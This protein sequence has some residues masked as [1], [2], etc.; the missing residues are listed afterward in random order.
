VPNRRI[1]RAWARAAL[2]LVLPAALLAVVAD[3]AVAP[4]VAAADTSF[5]FQGGG[6]GHGVGLSQYGARGA[7]RAG[8]NADQILQ[9]YYT[10][11]TVGTTTEPND[12]RIRIGAPSTA[13]VGSTTSLGSGVI[14]L[15]VDGTFV[16][17]AAKGTLITLSAGNGQVAARIGD[18]AAVTGSY[19]AVEY[20]GTGSVIQVGPGGTRF[21]KGVL[22]AQPNGSNVQININR[23]TMTE[24][25][26]GLA[27]MPSSWETPALEAQVVAARSYAIKRRRGPSQSFDLEASTVDQ[28]YAGYDKVA[29]GSFDRWK[30]AVDSTVSRVVKAPDGSVANALY[31]SGHGGISEDND[32]VFGTASG[33]GTPVSYLRSVQDPYEA[34]SDNPYSR[35]TR[36]YT[37]TELGQWFGISAVTGVRFSGSFGRSGRIDR[38]DVVMT[39]ASGSKTVKGADWRRTI[40]ANVPFDRELLSTLIINNPVGRLDSASPAPGGVLAR[41]WAWDPSTQDPAAVD[42]YIDGKIAV[43]GSANQPRP[44]VADAVPGAGANRGFAINAPASAGTHQVCAYAIDDANQNNPAIGCAS[45][46]VAATPLGNLENVTASQG[47]VTVS[48]WALDRSQTASIAVH[49]YVD[50]QWGGQGTADKPRPDVADVYPGYGANHGFGFAVAAANGTHQVCA[51]AIDDAGTNPQ[52]GCRSVNVTQGTV[53]GGGGGGGATGSDAIGSLDAVRRPNPKDPY[54]IQVSGWALDKDTTGPVQVHVYLDS[55]Y[56]DGQYLTAGT[57]N[58]SRPDVGA[59]YPGMGDQHGFSFTLTQPAGRHRIC[60]H[61]INAGS[62]GASTVIGCTTPANVAPIGNVESI[63]RLPDGKVRIQGWT[64]DPD[65]AKSLAVHVYRGGPVGGG[66]TFATSGTA[67]VARPD[68]SDAYPGFGAAHGFDVTIDAPGTNVPIYV[69][70]IDDANDLNPALGSKTV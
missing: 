67:N 6:F 7:A 23:L 14:T 37:G 36:S 48:G 19:A 13:T 38:A 68:V 63:T 39:T 43:R 9:H 4:T 49:I 64:L 2:A 1:L 31:S 55:P 27:E 22:V 46:T 66:G 33:P 44:D 50:G 53:G 24:Y 56:P 60:V 29:G 54:T 10:G 18:G 69:Y 32:Y 26:Y 8:L 40:N 17:T 59:A 62:A 35:W 58:T 57:A 28:V 47:G 42:I 45:V 11:A 61:A 65:N 30:A 20:V 3:A 52:I 5:T 16:G 51:Y 41:G 70:A 21:D 15:L 12:L 34:S 25:L